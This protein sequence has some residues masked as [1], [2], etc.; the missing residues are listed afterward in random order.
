MAKRWRIKIKC[1]CCERKY[2]RRRWEYRNYYSEKYSCWECEMESK[3]IHEQMMQDY[4]G[5]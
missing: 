3:M 4:Y 1:P 2:V 5:R